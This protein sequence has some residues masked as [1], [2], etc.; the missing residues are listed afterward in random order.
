MGRR[1]KVLGSGGYGN[2]IAL[3]EHR[4]CKLQGQDEKETRGVSAAALREMVALWVL[5]RVRNR[6]GHVGRMLIHSSGVVGIE[7]RRFRMNLLDWLRARCKRYRAQ[8]ILRLVGDVAAELAIAHAHGYIHRDVKPENVMLDE[9][10]RAH[11]IDWGLSRFT[12]SSRPARWTPG[13]A[14]LWYRAPELFTG[15]EYGPAV[16]IWALGVMVVELVAG[17]CPFRGRSELDQV[18]QYVEVLGPPPRDPSCLPQWPFPRSSSHAERNRTDDLWGS[19]PRL[20]AVP[21]LPDLVD[22]MLRWDADKRITA[23]GILLHP[24][25]QTHLRA[26]VL[27][28]SVRVSISLPPLV[29]PKQLRLGVVGALLPGCIALGLPIIPVGWC[30]ARFLWRAIAVS[31]RVSPTVP[32]L[33][34][35]VAAKLV[36]IQTTRGL[37]KS[38]STTRRQVMLINRCLGVP[39]LADGAEQS[40]LPLIT[41]NELGAN[42][43]ARD[44]AAML[45]EVAFLIQP[46]RVLPIRD[47]HLPLNAAYHLGAYVITGLAGELARC[48]QAGQKFVAKTA[49]GGFLLRSLSRSGSVLLALQLGNK[50][51]AVTPACMRFLQMW[52]R[53]R[54]HYAALLADV[55]GDAVRRHRLAQGLLVLARN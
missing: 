54:K 17:K 40:T 31:V 11:L 30:A 45:L 4:V 36:G 34:L 2:V 6:R 35:D 46:E 22:R 51:P 12:A 32:L 29:C 43:A 24:A 20:R 5:E 7:I 33:C 38:R 48:R 18:T 37:M 27:P 42:P 55:A 1:L 52:K 53:S 13:V 10:N 28:R 19:I 47:W 44:W 23:E 14:T 3:D 25:V 21:G 16:D 8:S 49:L 41:L 50:C 9:E 26:N 15:D 39:G